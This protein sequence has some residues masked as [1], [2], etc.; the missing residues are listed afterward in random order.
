[1]KSDQNGGW[2]IILAELLIAAL[3]Y[4]ILGYFT[5]ETAIVGSYTF[6]WSN[7][8]FWLSLVFIVASFQ[9]WN[10]IGPDKI[11]VR[12]IFGQ[13]IGTVTSGLPVVPP[14]IGEIQTFPTITQQKEFP[15][16]PQNI[17][18]AVDQEEPPEGKVPPLRIT[19]GE[20][21]TSDNAKTILGE[22]Y[23][24]AR[25]DGT[26]LTFQTEVPGDA[27]A[28]S[29]VTAEVTPIVR[30]RIT[31]A[32]AFVKNIGTIE[33]VNRQIEDE[34]VVI[35]NTV[36]PRIS[37]AQAQ[38]NVEWTNALLFKAVERRIGAQ[39][40]HSDEWG[41]DLEGAAIKP[42][43]FNRALN[44]SISGVA[45]AAFEGEAVV[46]KARRDAEAT[47]LTGKATATARQA[48]E[49]GTVAGKGQGIA[50][51]AKSTGLST[52]EIIGAET[53]QAVGKGDSTIIV[54]ADGIS[55]LAG[56]AA[57]FAPKRPQPKANEE[58]S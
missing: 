7:L 3:G 1:M 31:D 15:A 52:A 4:L 18:R 26:P 43:S 32:V 57:A 17:Y 30:W 9:F 36:Y 27:L 55:Q 46:R 2:K 23:Q 20:S 42:I 11:G 49:K 5:T 8:W 24:V 25:A 19:F 48:L 22:Y 29:R 40:G 50:A 39:Q 37:V 34:M 54:G 45:Q 6:S 12:T 16:E 35:L 28:N 10:V 33:E 38:Q 53:A 47:V 21:L 41:I 44:K 58:T 56:I 13:P 51:A 14:G